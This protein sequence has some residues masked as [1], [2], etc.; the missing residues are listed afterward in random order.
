MKKK[1]VREIRLIKSA[2]K[3]SSSA[4]VYVALVDAYTSDNNTSIEIS[5]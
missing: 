4:V 3:S 1:I 2:E 5:Y